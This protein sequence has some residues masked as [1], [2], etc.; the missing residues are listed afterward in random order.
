MYR[1]KVDTQTWRCLVIGVV[2]IHVGIHDVANDYCLNVV[3]QHIAPH[4]KDCNSKAVADVKDGFILESV[5]DRYGGND[6]ACVGENHRPPAQVEVSSP[7]MDNLVDM[8]AP[9]DGI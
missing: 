8:L 2:F 1:D 7:L 4:Y 6:E 9:E 5:A 3:E